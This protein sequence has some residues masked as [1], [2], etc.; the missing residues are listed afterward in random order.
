MKIQAL[1]PE[2]QKSI[3]SYVQCTYMPPLLY[4]RIPNLMPEMNNTLLGQD[5]VVISCTKPT[6]VS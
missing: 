4:Y 1:M 6:G 5:N 3:L 2:M